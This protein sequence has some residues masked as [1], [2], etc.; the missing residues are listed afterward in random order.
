MGFQDVI[1]QNGD[2]RANQN[3]ERLHGDSSLSFLSRSFPLVLKPSWLGQTL[4]TGP[5]ISSPPL[6]GPTD[7]AG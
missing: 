5:H 1:S 2:F 7:F 4:P 6:S 3:A